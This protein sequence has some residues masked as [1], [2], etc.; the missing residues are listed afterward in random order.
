[1]NNSN[2]GNLKVFS[3]PFTESIQQYEYYCIAQIKSLKVLNN[4][5]IT[6]DLRTQIENT[7]LKQL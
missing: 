4:Q 1:M 6:S 3:N 2:V 5:N 7:K